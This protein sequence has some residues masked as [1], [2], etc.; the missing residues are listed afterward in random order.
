MKSERLKKKNGGKKKVIYWIINGGKPFKNATCWIVTLK[1]EFPFLL[2]RVFVEA[3]TAGRLGR[4]AWEIRSS[5]PAG[6]SPPGWFLTLLQ[7]SRFRVGK[8]WFFLRKKTA[9][10]F[11]FGVM[12]FLRWF[13]NPHKW[14]K[15]L[16]FHFW[17][18]FCMAFLVYI[19][20]F[21]ANLFQGYFF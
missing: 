4:R 5:S 17:V 21:L 3:I 14:Q 8:P 16:V 13:E 2:F 20:V 18:F 1:K 9:H 6:F 7:G 10:N 12:R 19:I 11:F 15:L